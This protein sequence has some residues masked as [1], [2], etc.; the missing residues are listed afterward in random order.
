MAPGIAD[1]LRA[2]Q[3]VY[4]ISP[5]DVP[6][7]LGEL[8]RIRALLWAKMFLPGSSPERQ[9]GQTVPDVLTIPEVAGALRF[10][11]GPCTN[12]SGAVTCGLFETAGPSGCLPQPWQ[13]GRAGI[14]LAQLTST[15]AFHYH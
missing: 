12:W 10:S 1:L 7:I 2:L 9:A 4:D 14:G 8:E 11:R 6:P 15:I 5:R 3:A 13:S